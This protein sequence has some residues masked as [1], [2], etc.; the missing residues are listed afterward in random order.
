MS[1]DD[2]HTR[3]EDRRESV[4]TR[5]QGN[6]EHQ[7]RITEDV[8]S[9]RRL[10]AYRLTRFIYLLFGVLESLIGLRI[11]FKLIEANAVNPFAHFVYRIT[12]LFLKPFVGLTVN[13]ST[14]GIV[15]EITSLIAM[16]VYAMFGWLIV[17]LAWLIFYRARTRTVTVYEKEHR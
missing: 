8:A 9:E 1:V 6:L 15:L 4:I 13:P 2:I 3:T 7:E 5:Q 14:G 16:L 10:F 11:L 17:Q 12:D